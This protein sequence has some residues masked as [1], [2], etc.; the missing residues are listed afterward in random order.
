MENAL[1][2]L[3]LPSNIEETVCKR[4]EDIR[5]MNSNVSNWFTMK[6]FSSLSKDDIS[7]LH[8]PENSTTFA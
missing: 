7:S 2:S 8:Y 5:K 3:L 6:N 1:K 4:I